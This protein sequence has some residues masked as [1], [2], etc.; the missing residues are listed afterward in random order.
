VGA[1]R[2][3]ICVI[4][5]CAA[6]AAA[7]CTGANAA[8]PVRTDAGVARAYGHGAGKVWVITP[9]R[10]R[11]RS[12]V[13]FVHGWTATSPFDWHQPWLDHLVARGSVVLFPAYQAGR[14]DDS[15]TTTPAALRTGLVAGFRALGAA[16]LP[17]VVA[18]YSVGGALAFEYAAHAA[19]W[20]LP[21]PSAVMS[22]FP[23]DPLQVDPPLLDL[24]P[25][26]VR[27]LVLAGDRDEVV[28][29][30]GAKEFWQWLAPVPARLKTYRLLRSTKSLVFQHE[31]LKALGNPAVR[32]AFWAPLDDLVA[33]A[34]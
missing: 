2:L 16:R 32:A 21:R 28:G 6:V 34:R 30:T 15:F 20:G 12:V 25:P 3:R 24:G 13:V 19:G 27:V 1:A 29:Q 31:A 10:G 8:S 18:G 7:V 17:V 5:V 4:A 14:P 33:A 22:I 11:P 23:V 26:R 9:K